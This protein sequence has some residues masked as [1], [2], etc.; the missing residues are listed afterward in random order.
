VISSPV[1]RLTMETLTSPSTGRQK[2]GRSSDD[3]PA[4]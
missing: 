3:L 2:T 4:R 1:R